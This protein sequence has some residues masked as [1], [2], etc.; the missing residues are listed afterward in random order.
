MS[1]FITSSKPLRFLL[2]FNSLKITFNK[3]KS[4]NNAITQGIKPTKNAIFKSSTVAVLATSFSISFK[5]LFKKKFSLI[6]QLV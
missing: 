3:P 1:V 2:G 5:I 4:H 6:I